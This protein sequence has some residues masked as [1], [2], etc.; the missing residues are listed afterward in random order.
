MQS[1]KFAQVNA[2]FLGQAH[3][4]LSDGIDDSTADMYFT[5]VTQN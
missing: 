5:S 3:F 1:V 4:I 2:T